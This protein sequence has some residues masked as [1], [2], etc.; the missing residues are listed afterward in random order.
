MSQRTDDSSDDRIR[1]TETISIPSSVVDR[2]DR[3]LQRSE[4]DTVDEYVTY[5]L[6]EVLGRIEDATDESVDTVDESEI[7]TRLKSLGYLD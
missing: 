3:R 1:Q 2:V 5:V 7:E 6:Q 4:F